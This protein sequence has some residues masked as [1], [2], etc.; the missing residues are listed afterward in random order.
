MSYKEYFKEINACKQINKLAKKYRNKKIIIYGTGIM[1]TELIENYDIAK[2]NIVG[3]CDS[4]Y[5]VGSNEKFFG[6]KTFNPK[7]LKTLDFEVLLFCLYNSDNL[8][9]NI[10]YNILINTKNEDI[11]VDDLLKTNMMFLIK[12][13]FV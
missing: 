6:Y 7:E 10:V 8:K 11:V 9:N 3:F 1:C 2:L 13:M 4:K 5:K 12:Q